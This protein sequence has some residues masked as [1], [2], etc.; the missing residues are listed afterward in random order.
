MRWTV[1][2]KLVS[3]FV[4]GA[5]L[6][7]IT[8]GFA[9]KNLSDMND[10]AHAFAD[11]WM[12]GVAYAGEMT[13]DAERYRRILNVLVLEDEPAKIA[14]AEASLKEAAVSIR[15][16][17]DLYAPT[18][19]SEEDRTLF[20]ETKQALEE[21]IAEGE[22][23]LELARANR[24]AE[25]FKFLS[26]VA[27]PKFNT[28]LEA[29]HSLE[30]FN[31]KSGKELA[32][33]S[34]A[35]F[36]KTLWMT[37]G[38]SLLSLIGGIGIGLWLT[39]QITRGLGAIGAAAE[40]VSK[41][42]LDQRVVLKQ[43]DE[44]GDLARSFE[45]MTAYLQEVAGVAAAVSQGDLSKTIAP[46]SAQDQFGTA[47]ARMVASLRQVVEGVRRGAD[48]VASASEEIS[49][50][51]VEL[52]RTV[53][54]Q[55][56]TA[57]VTER[58]NDELTSAVN[59]TGSSIAELAASVQQVAS[60][61]AHANQVSVETSEAARAGEQAVNETMSGMATISETMRTVLSTIRVLDERSA[62][63]G[64]IIEVIED[65]ADQTNLLALNAAIEAARAG[66][67]GR[68]FAV[69]A[70]EV[71]KLAERSTRAT[72]EIAQL[73]KGIQG[74][75]TKAVDVTRQGASKVEEGSRLANRTNEALL[76]IKDG[77]DQLATVLAEIAATTDEQARASSQ[78]AS[79]ADQMTTIN[80]QV[81][82]SVEELTR[83]AQES[84]TATEQVA[85]TAEDLSA[86]ARELQEAVG[87]FRLEEGQAR[88]LDVRIQ[89]PLA[90]PAR[91]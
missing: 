70:E 80:G 18:I 29:A 16:T 54:A 81:S 22:R 61:V 1:G 64:S 20:T 76:R 44:L 39:R 43:D 87:F 62:E 89:T 65:I 27:R 28:A 74:E 48:S 38:L 72:G 33:Q 40:G 23:S 46:K 59:Q 68:G 82:G 88:Q 32:V 60:S 69:V 7:L 4:A 3:G 55:A 15:K 25:A 12:Q 86:Q 21:A 8:G 85:R 26:D 17:A 90:L 71:R 83:S 9:L 49:S 79:A 6:T 58:S 75:T 30:Q 41:G 67:Q 57:R 24:D 53:A 5:V 51:S 66:E 31:L 78:I 35:D 56:E 63:I 13:A 84:A 2:R 19:E 37:I 45:R 91:W 77:A 52:S 42:D 10:L 14:A 34:S 47:I 73:I 36:Q 11:N 50:S